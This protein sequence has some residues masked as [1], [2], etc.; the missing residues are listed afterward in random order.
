MTPMRGIGIAVF[1]FSF[2][3]RSSFAYGQPECDLKK[4]KDGIKV[5]TCKS[6]S[7]KFRSLIAE[8]ELENISFE[9]LETFLWDVDNYV[10]WQYNMME[11]GLIKK[12][13]DNQMIYRSVIDA[14]WPVDD[15]ELL[16]QFHV[17]QSLAPDQLFF[18]I[19]SITYD[20]PDKEGVI[21]VPYSNAS[22][23][24]TKIGT[25]LH[26]KYSLHIDPGG[27]VPSL[28]VNMAM[29]EGPYVSFRNLKTMIEKK[30][31]E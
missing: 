24:V 8:F 7:S 17:N 16:V 3:L 9:A 21:R 6:D 28:L 18:L 29:A 22:W 20:Y 31:L 26:V 15:R 11:S 13:N 27:Y 25:G 12:I 4:D 5:Y 10:N 1:Y 2:I 19:Y 14:P 23:Q 30:R